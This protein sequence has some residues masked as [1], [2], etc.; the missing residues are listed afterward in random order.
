MAGGP[1][2][3]GLM[4]G[5]ARRS[6]SSL[7]VPNYRRFFCGQVVSISGNWMQNVAEVWLVLKLTHAGWAVGLVA[8]FQF[9]P[10]LLG[11][12]WGGVLADR[13]AKR[14]LLMVTQTLMA[15]PA[16]VLF[17]LAA[18]GIAEVW[19]VFAL[20][21]VRG[22]VNAVDYPARQAL[23]MEMVGP[24]RVVNAVSL[25]S[26]LVH[27]ARVLGP[28]AAGAVIALVGVAPCFALNA[29]SFGAMLVALARMDPA[30][31]RPAPPVAREPGQIREAVA[32][33]RRTPA[34]LIPIASMAL[35][36]TFSFNFQVL[37]PLLATF[38]WQGTA[39]T[40]AL[41]TTTMAVGSVA[42]ALAAG[43][44]GRAD[45]ALLVR[46]S[47]LF[48]ALTLLAAA[49]PV[50]PLQLLV[51]LPL[52]AASVTFAA[53]VN[54]ALQLAVEPAMRGRVLALYSVV[55]LGSTPIGAP[56]AGWL[57][58]AAGPRAGL[59]LGGVAA[60]VAALGARLAWARLAPPTVTPPR[61]V[62]RPAVGR[63]PA[64]GE[65]HPERGRVAASA[66]TRARPPARRRP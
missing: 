1:T 31:L 14:R 16:L 55:F 35:V 54:S 62:G 50:L 47:A 9:L 38:T 30:E 64:R 60:L 34:L 24:D 44:R 42:G 45:G 4:R 37:L 17:G 23:V 59:A 36:G 40:Y 27:T 33:V 41:L 8:A 58:G 7:S 63:R 65:A 43:A 51:L 28:A 21:L 6:L 25:N 46:A 52:G 48:G 57:A 20:V 3:G 19:M 32:Y 66:G 13:V 10:F 5:A 39:A 56:I 2:A 22:T 15:L 53:G 11:G 12:A 61:A 29:L 49:A 18:G 26:V